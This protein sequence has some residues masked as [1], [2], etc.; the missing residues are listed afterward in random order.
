MYHLA[1]S[2]ADS[3]IVPVLV[4]G[5]ILLVLGIGFTFAARHEH[6]RRVAVLATPRTLA[7]DV[8]EGPVE[9]SG[10]AEA[11]PAGVVSSPY[12]GMV[13]LHITWKIEEQRRDAQGRTRW[14][15]DERGE[16]GV[17]FLL[18]DESGVVAIDARSADLELPERVAPMAGLMG[19]SGADVRIPWGGTAGTALALGVRP[20]RVREKVL[21]AGTPLYVLGQATRGAGVVVASGERRMI[22]STKS[23][24]D[25]VRSLRARTI[26]WS[27]VAAAGTLCGA[28]L[29]VWG[30][31]A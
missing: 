27:G 3:M 12:T 2:L 21:V 18:R 19:G 16:T 11:G 30:S 10:V 31:L 13:G 15:T 7:R 25:L 1:S 23:E 17:P 20:R 5:A 22:I 28:A 26:L 6:A 29:L 14:H 24:A 9:L 8:R 4:G